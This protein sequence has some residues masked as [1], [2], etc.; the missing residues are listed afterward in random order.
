MAEAV[1]EGDVFHH[2]DR[3]QERDSPEH[4]EKMK[5]GALWC[6]SGHFQCGD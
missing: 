4:F 2:R 3:Q 5:G 6:N 1:K